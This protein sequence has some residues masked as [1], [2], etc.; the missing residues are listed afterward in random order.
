[1]RGRSGAE[2]APSMGER[3]DEAARRPG[4]GEQRGGGTEGSRL[5]FFLL[6][7]GGGWGV[8]FPHCA[9]VWSGVRLRGFPLPLRMRDGAALGPIGSHPKAFRPLQPYREPLRGLQT[10]LVLQTAV[11]CPSDYLSPKPSP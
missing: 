9:P 8:D 11:P 5:G 6:G 2:R 1:M 3:Q 7:I 4:A 10:P